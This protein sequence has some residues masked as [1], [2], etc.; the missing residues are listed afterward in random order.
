MIAGQVGSKATR[1]AMFLD[2]FSAA[3]LP[4]AMLASAVLSALGVLLMA[5]GMARFGPGRLVPLLYVASAT[6]YVAEWV[7]IARSPEWTV[8][9]IYVHVAAL[10]ALLI[11]GFWSVVSER[12]DPHTAKKVIRRVTAGATA[13]GLVGGLLAERVSAMSS[14]RTMLLVL[15]ALNLIC[16]VG[17]AFISRGGSVH[18]PG[19]GSSVMA[20]LRH[21]GA[22]PY[23]RMLAV[24]VSL[25]ALVSGVLDYAFKAEADRV[26]E[27]GQQLMSFFAVFYTATGLLTL[28]AQTLLSK[29]SLER[30]GI[31]GTIALMPAAVVLGGVL[32]AAVT[33][34]WTVVLVRG[35]EHVLSNSLYRSVYELLFTPLSPETKRP[36]K[37]LIDVGFQRFGDAAASGLVMGVLAF[38]PA[39]GTRVS[40]LVASGAS[41]FALWIALRL[42]RGYVHELEESLRSGRVVLSES[43]IGDATT[44]RTLA[45]TTMAMDR[46]KLLVEI[47]ALRARSGDEGAALPQPVEAEVAARARPQRPSLDALSTSLDDLM[48]GETSR[49]DRAL[50]G[51]LDPR[52]VAFVI[53][54][55]GDEPHARAARRALRI[56]AP[57]VAGQLLDALL[58]PEQSERVRRRLPDLLA[59]VRTGQVASGL[60]AA[61][62]RSSARVRARCT[63]ALQELVDHDPSLAPSHAEVFEAARRELDEAPVSVPRIFMVLGLALDPEPM[64]LALAALRSSDAN[65]RGTSFEYL[66]NVLPESLRADLWP[67]LRDYA[68]HEL[69]GGDGPRSG[70]SPTQMAEELR[71]SADSLTIDREL[72]IPLHEDS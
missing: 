46:A 33:R 59:E 28:L 3:E 64:K 22:A 35:V 19:D 43:E 29:R 41:A 18:P 34:L 10:G 30:L 7:F 58:D 54:L 1:D 14:P 21:L 51:P 37:T 44:R 17:V 23:L 8:A 50:E 32:G 69:P 57:R 5:Q 66:E 48:S 39:Y 49:I 36:T 16:G 65:L 63:K 15:A 26:F 38:A 9:L 11:S 72:L 13:G 67:H 53:P 24:L 55:L 4:K 56:V 31:G 20:G 47:E 12:F 45:D 61:L 62:A 2:V 42:H 52:L 27:G 70:R 40:V 6:A 25:V 71:R 68:A 60:F